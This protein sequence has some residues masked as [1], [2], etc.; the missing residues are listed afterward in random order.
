[1]SVSSVVARTSGSGRGDRSMRF[2]A[3]RIVRCDPSS[4]GALPD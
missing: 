1:M 2:A 3:A 4:P